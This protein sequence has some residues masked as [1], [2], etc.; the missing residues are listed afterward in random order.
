MSTPAN[1]IGTN[2]P[3]KILHIDLDAFYASVEALDNP[4]LI[5]QPIIV[6]GLGRRGVVATASY[7]ARKNGVHSAMPME[8]ARRSCP[9]AVFLRPRFGRYR[10]LSEQVFSIYEAWTKR[11]EKPSLDE[12]YLDVTAHISSPVDIAKSIRASIH[13]KTGLTGSAGVSTNKFLAKLAS[14][15]D[16]PNGLTVIRPEEA[17][18]F[19]A[20]LPVERLWGVGPANAE[21]L[22]TNGFKQI[23][24]LAVSSLEDLQRLFGERWGRQLWEFAHG[25]DRRRVEPPSRPKSISSET[26]YEHDQPSWEAVW[27]NI[28]QFVV[29]MERGLERWSLSARTVTLK[30]RFQD[31][32]TIT[33]S[34]TPMVPVRQAD[35]IMRVARKLVDRVPL[36]GRRIR[37]VGLGGSNL[38]RPGEQ[39]SCPDDGSPRQLGLFSP[40]ANIP[41][42]DSS[43]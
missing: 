22:R 21:R 42:E 31:F 13:R 37:L 19:L 25:R 4:D 41:S 27:P 28:K 23:G 26:T 38:I 24:E 11:V 32:T 12:A 14:D 16:K 5:G 33:R 40:S 30:V 15:I 6:G 7:E 18:D 9:N 34:H 10:E 36:D 29:D 35:E 8:R 39:T 3:R 2:W 43:T 20:P 1:L 17:Q